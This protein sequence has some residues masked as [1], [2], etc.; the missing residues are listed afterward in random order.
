MLVNQNALSDWLEYQT[1]KHKEFRQREFCV[2]PGS[3]G[4]K[5]AE[6]KNRDFYG[7]TLLNGHVYGKTYYSGKRYLFVTSYK[8]ITSDTV[9]VYMKPQTDLKDTK[10]LE[11]M[12]INVDVKAPFIR[13][14][15][16]VRRY[17]HIKKV[18]QITVSEQFDRSRRSISDEITSGRKWKRNSVYGF[19]PD[20][21]AK[22]MGVATDIFTKDERMYQFFY[23]MPRFDIKQ[24]ESE[25]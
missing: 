16:E 24:N 9:E 6:E 5:V 4:I 7:F 13:Y 11:W 17:Y 21:K 23:I 22:T 3:V 14:V 20:I 8:H 25:N 19:N 12:R 1:R 18:E 2:I 10:M 15:A